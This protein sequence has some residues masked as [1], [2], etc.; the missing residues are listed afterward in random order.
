MNKMAVGNDSRAYRPEI[1]GLRAISVVSV[2]LYAIGVRWLAFLLHLS[3]ALA[4]ICIRKVRSD[5]SIEPARRAYP[6]VGCP[7]D[8]VPLLALH[9]TPPRLGSKKDHPGVYRRV[10][11]HCHLLGIWHCGS[12]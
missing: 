2:V 6:I 11:L 4:D 9:R 1:D 7:D 3:L 5:R 12:N 10:Q 8:G